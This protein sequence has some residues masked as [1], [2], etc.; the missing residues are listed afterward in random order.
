[1]SFLCALCS[2]IAVIE[3]FQFHKVCSQVKTSQNTQS[4]SYSMFVPK[5]NF[6][7]GSFQHLLEHQNDCNF[8][9]LIVRAF[10]AKFFGQTPESIINATHPG[11]CQ[12]NYSKRPG[13]GFEIRVSF[14]PAMESFETL[15]DR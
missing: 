13:P 1:M 2:N 4:R 9:R 8:C 10:Q 11:S 6:S 12:C 5:S 15:A 14:L 7:V 3:D